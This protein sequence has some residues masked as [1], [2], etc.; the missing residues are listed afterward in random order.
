MTNASADAPTRSR[1]ALLRTTLATQR[2][3]LTIATLI[4]LLWMGGKV[5]VP[6]LVGI[7]IDRGI[8][9]NDRVWLWAGLVA[10]AGIASGVFTASH[11]NTVQAP[12]PHTVNLR[13]AE[14][15]IYI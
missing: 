11:N 14:G 9:A 3:N 8:E 1:W 5:A 6:R 15:S 7:G 13:Q 10:A 4:G 2:R 12:F